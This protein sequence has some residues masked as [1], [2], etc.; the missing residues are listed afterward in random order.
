MKFRIVRAAK[1]VTPPKKRIYHLSASQTL[2]RMARRHKESIDFSKLFEISALPDL[3]RPRK[4]RPRLVALRAFFMAVGARIASLVR[5]SAKRLGEK[6]RIQR[7]RVR[8]WRKKR[9]SRHKPESLYFLSGALCASLC[10][11]LLCGLFTVALLF[12][13]YGGLYRT[14]TVPSLV[15]LPYDE[16]VEDDAFFSFVVDY[17]EHPTVAP[18]TVIA[19][20]PPAGVRRRIYSRGRPCTVTLTVSCASPSYTLADLVGASQRDALLALR[21]HGIGYTLAEAYSDTV[22]AGT[23]LSQSPAPGTTLTEADRVTL[24]ISQGPLVI[25]SAVPSLVGLS[26]REAVSRLLSAGLAVGEVSYLPSDRPSG[27][28]LS[29]SVSASSL[30]KPGSAVSFTVSAGYSYSQKT[31]PSLYGLT[32]DEAAVRL[33]AYG[34][35]IGKVSTSADGTSGGRIVAQSPLPDTPIT[36]SVVAVDVYLGS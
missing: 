16:T 7:E 31:V 33:R 11:T 1:R 23:V 14:A 4:R 30:V 2:S 29:Q 6:T 15:G 20:S 12:G 8:V 5:H 26:E 36:S 13:S 28:V 27:T 35:V 25:P 3:Y 24:T 22:P 34:L 32:P 19:Q 17:R 18:G 10:V 21:N 9:Q